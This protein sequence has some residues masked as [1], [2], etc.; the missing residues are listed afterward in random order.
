METVLA[1][2]RV[3]LVS[4]RSELAQLTSEEENVSVYLERLRKRKAKLERDIPEL[5]AQLQTAEKGGE[6]A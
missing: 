5:E 2:L 4:Y 3:A 6:N 1:A